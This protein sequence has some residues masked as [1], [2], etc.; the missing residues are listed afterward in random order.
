VLTPLLL[1]WLPGRAFSLKSLGPALFCALLLLFLRWEDG[2]DASGP[3]EMIGWVL[4]ILSTAAYLA[5][6]FT[7]ASTY[8]S[9]SGVK[10]EMRR[11]L[12]FQIAGGVLGLGLWVC[13]MITIHGV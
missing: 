12:P 10:R 11:S 4:V 2:L 1:P 9:L 6:N 5:M 3:L 8:T 13:S 7:G